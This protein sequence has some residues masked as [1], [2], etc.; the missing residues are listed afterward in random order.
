MAE[1]K[2]MEEAC[3][4][5]FRTKVQGTLVCAAPLVCARKNWFVQCD[6][7]GRLP[8]TT[9]LLLPLRSSA[10]VCSPSAAL[11]QRSEAILLLRK[12]ILK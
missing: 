12:T 11:L 1:F 6:S 9:C 8:R 7:V 2:V 4:R 3:K 5:F 10:A